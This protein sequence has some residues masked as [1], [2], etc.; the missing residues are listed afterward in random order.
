VKRRHFCFIHAANFRDGP[1]I[2][3]HQLDLITR[4]GLYNLL[5][6]VSITILGPPGA[7]ERI[8]PYLDRYERI[9]VDFGGEPL[10]M[11]EFPTLERLHRHCRRCPTSTALYIHTKGIA[12]D[13]KRKITVSN[14]RRMMEH[15][16]IER[17]QDVI[18]LLDNCGVVGCNFTDKGGKPSVPSPHY[19]GN[20]WWANAWHINR[21]KR[22]SGLDW[23]DRRQAEWWVLGTGVE[24][25]VCI[26]NSG[27]NHQ[28]KFYPRQAYENAPLLNQPVRGKEK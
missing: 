16:L 23:A 17:H 5:S 19:S 1:E 2:L 26:H 3:E 18:P 22:V 4:T 27:V 14:W 21:L 8:Q 6:R 9:R 28:F 11:W 20:F 12:Y 10:A 24:D 13:G 15:F 7:V 25:A